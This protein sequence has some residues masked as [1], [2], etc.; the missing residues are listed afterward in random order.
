MLVAPKDPQFKVCVSFSVCIKFVCNIGITTR[1]SLNLTRNIFLDTELTE[2]K[3]TET[4]SFE[5]VPISQMFRMDDGMG[6]LK[7]SFFS[8][9][10]KP[11]RMG[12]PSIG[13]M[14]IIVNFENFF[15]VTQNIETLEKVEIRNTRNY[16]PETTNLKK[17][18]R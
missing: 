7:K 11:K 12:S 4:I 14:I 2:H 5:N 3:F 17:K 8:F 16:K 9:T 13:L 10:I 6:Y 18:N 1:L 15:R